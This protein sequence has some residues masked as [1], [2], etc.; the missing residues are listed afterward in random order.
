MAKT[1]G[2]MRWRKLGRIFDPAEHRSWIKSHAQVPTPF[3]MEDRIRVFVADRNAANKSFLTWFDVDRADP[4]R[5]LGAREGSVMPYGRTGMF[6]DD[7]MMP[8]DVVTV[9][10]ELWMYYTGWNQGVTVPY[11]NSIGL[12]RSRD[13][14][15]S[16]E[17]CFEGPVVD[18]SP[19][20]PLMAVTPVI[21]RDDSTWRMW[22]VSG[23]RWVEVDGKLEPVY[24]IRHATSSDGVTWARDGA[25]CVAQRDEFE[26]H[27]H[28]SVL[29][30]ADGYHMWFCHR[31]SRDFRDGAGSY[32]IGYAYAA[33]GRSWVRRDGDAGIDVSVSGWDSTM[34]CYP[35]VVS[36]DGKIYMFYNGNGFGRSGVG[37]AVLET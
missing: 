1:L 16:F 29:R 11:R 34:L 8:G 12:A 24:V 35:Y 18:R 14:G 25:I 36:V 30:R 28:P 23:T 32:R 10:D 17:R 22:Y 31:D 33:D 7:G 27:A 20:E 37:V 26:A 3:V 6:D 2:T 9:S 4:M 21:L 15:A 13:G 19:I 5:V